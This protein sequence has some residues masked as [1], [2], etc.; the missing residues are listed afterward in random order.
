MDKRGKTLFDQAIDILDSGGQGTLHAHI[1][2]TIHVSK[3]E[4]LIAFTSAKNIQW[5]SFSK[6]IPFFPAEV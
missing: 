3:A 2:V 6:Y 5:F 1:L 4:S